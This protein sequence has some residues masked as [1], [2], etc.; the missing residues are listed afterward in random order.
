MAFMTR[1][2][3]AQWSR[4]DARHC[5][6]GVS[7]AL[8]AISIFAL[9]GVS[10]LLID[11]VTLYVARADAQRVANAAALAGAKA[12]VDGGVTANPTNTG[13]AWGPA[14]LL[15]TAEAH[16][17]ISTSKIGGVAVPSGETVC[18]GSHVILPCATACPTTGSAGSGFGVNPQVGITVQ[19]ASLPLF[20]AKILGRATAT[21]SAGGV[22]EGF[23]SSG[24]NVPVASRGVM[25]WLIP[26]ID[27]KN[28]GTIIDS[29]TGQMVLPGSTGFI[30]E[31]IKLNMGC[32]VGGCATLTAPNPV[33]G[34]PAQSTF[35]PI[36]LANAP[37][38]GPSCS[39]AG[40]AY[41]R[42]LV[43]SN[44]TPVAC[45]ATATVETT[46]IPSAA[47]NQAELNCRIGAN[48]GNGQDTIDSTFPFRMEASDNN[49]LVLNG[50]VGEGDAISTSPSV[51]TIPLYDAGASPGPY[52]APSTPVIIG[53]VQAFVEGATGGNPT[54]QIMNVSGCGATA[55]GASP[56]V[57]SDG[58]S[59]VP[60]RLIHP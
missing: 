5:Q 31:Q 52:L 2:S 30:G 44:P 51:V 14:C 18:F 45:G 13:A 40:T 7:I 38:M 25:P 9:F 36:T 19:S 32:P 59:A 11:V 56:A 26:N 49:P 16:Q 1:S 50:T 24:T 55:R 8:V 58:D 43:A 46:V 47:A 17:I 53:F 4:G 35:Y 15:A 33:V 3:K 20:F 29:T 34:T 57:G 21:V 22:A 12:L 23:N 10:A 39:T 48:P 60:V 54:I 42:N 37:A 41:E 27:P 6:R 28:G